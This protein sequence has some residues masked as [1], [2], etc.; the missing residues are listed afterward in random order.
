MAFD[1]SGKYALLDELAEEF[2]ARYR[3]GERPSLQEYIDRHPDLAEAIREFFPSVVQ[4]EM[5]DA[6]C[7]APVAPAPSL[8]PVVRQVGDYAILR[9]VGRGG[10]GV[11]YEAE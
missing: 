10:M 6:D 8:P 1:M 5:V 3:R 2:A 11:V 9:E 4:L 7:R